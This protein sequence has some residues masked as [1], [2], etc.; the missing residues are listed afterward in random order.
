MSTSTG[1][2]VVTGTLKPCPPFDFFK[3]L[4]FLDGFEPTEGEQVLAPDSLTKAVTLNGR[5]VAFK[6]HS[7]GAIEEPELVYTLYSEQP[8]SEAEYAAIL[9]RMRFFLSLDDD[10][11]PFYEIGRAD[12][13]FAPML[14][15]FYGL[16]Q[17]KFLTPFEIACWAILGQR[18]P[19]RVA[20]NIKMGMV[21]RWGTSITLPEGSYQA[22]PEPA[23]MAAVD[24]AKLA[25]V[26]RN[27]RKV[28]YL[29]AVIQFFNEVDEQF[30]RYGDHDEVAAA[31]RGV[32]GIGEWSA[33]FIMVRG[34]GRMER[35]SAVDQELAKAAARV[36]NQ[37]HMLAPSEMQILLDRYGKYQG[38]WALYL[39]SPQ[40]L[41]NLA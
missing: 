3:T 5:A 35:V 1:L 29:R 40:T 30:L 23:Q 13:A 19:W 28:E 24:A 17:P 32:R 14:E 20:H 26:V 18:I 22:F 27:E 8:L 7:T 37:G 21:K 6:L 25:S 15:R 2:S 10:L 41:E 11:R 33:H 38:Y 12:D 34:L 36:Y 4:G 39:R 9:D 31:I 16:H